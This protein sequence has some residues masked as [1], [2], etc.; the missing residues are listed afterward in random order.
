MQA[1]H[2]LR[3]EFFFGRTFRFTQEAPPNE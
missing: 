3:D 2:I 1:F